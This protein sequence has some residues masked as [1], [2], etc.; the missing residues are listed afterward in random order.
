[1]ASVARR[2][3]RWRARF[4]DA[5]GREYARHFDRK[6]DAQRWLDEQTASQVRGDFVAPGAGR[7]TFKEYAEQWRAMQLHHRAT[8]REQCES[9]LR[10][11]VYPVI[12]DHPL[13]AIRRS[14]VQNVVNIAAAKLAPATVQVVYAYLSAVLKSATQD[15]LIPSTPCVKISLPERVTAR[16]QPLTVEQVG[17]IANAVS[18]RYRAMVIVAA[19]SGLRGGELRGLTLDRI[20]PALHLAGDIVP[21]SATLTVDRQ[22]LAGPALPVF[23]PPKTSAAD[24][25]VKVGASVVDVLV[26]HL[27][28]FGVGESGLVFTSSSGAPITRSTAGDIWRRATT[29]LTLRPRSGWHDLRHFHA[30]LLIADGRSVRSVADRLG[31][32]DPAETL[33]TYAH[34]WPDDE[35]R[36]VRATE[37][38]LERLA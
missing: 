5:T 22:L 1:M 35:D 24:R 36:A 6:V 17:I 13:Q 8:T 4:R 30:S 32:A 23:G 37:A 14:D 28:E 27:Q 16:V 33:R 9:R 26:A 38:V 12:G 19:G 7:V 34:L 18:A 3:D 31:H 29:S 10:Q 25:R 11:H 21:R 2:G 15:R 20:S